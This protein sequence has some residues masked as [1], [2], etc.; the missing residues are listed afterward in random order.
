MELL[1]SIAMGAALIEVYAWLPSFCRWLLERAVSI[2]PSDE[3][4]RWRSEW[5]TTLEGLPN[6]AVRLAHALSLV[7]YGAPRIRSD[8]REQTLEELDSVLL[9]ELADFEIHLQAKAD[10]VADR[11]KEFASHGE[12]IG[13]ELTLKMR[14]ILGTVANCR[15]TIDRSSNLPAMASQDLT[16]ALARCTTVTEAQ[17]ARLLEVFKKAKFLEYAEDLIRATENAARTAGK[18]RQAFEAL[19]APGQPFREWEAALDAACDACNAD[20]EAMDK[21]MEVHK[22]REIEDDDYN[23]DW[24]EV[25]AAFGALK[26]TMAG[27]RVQMSIE[28]KVAN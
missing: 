22:D 1:I 3:Q 25:E 19:R 26:S 9:P 20:I 8:F 23:C 28:K 27:V 12:Q 7:L 18:H 6:S 21:W 4:E 16:E 24:T 2:V 17:T 14:E 15:N 11:L 13:S 5:T 10:L